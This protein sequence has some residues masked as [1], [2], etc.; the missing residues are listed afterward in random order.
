MNRDKSEKRGLTLAKNKTARMEARLGLDG[1]P[2]DD[3]DVALE[4]LGNGEESQHDSRTRTGL[5]TGHYR[6]REE[7]PHASRIAEKEDGT[8]P[9]MRGT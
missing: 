5:R 2:L 4:S 3:V 6:K 9:L 1:V 8:R 7:S